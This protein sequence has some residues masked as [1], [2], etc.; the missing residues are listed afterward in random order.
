MDHNP[1]RRHLAKV[2]LGGFNTIARGL[3][4]RSRSVAPSSTGRP[5]GRLI[6]D[7]MTSEGIQ[8]AVE[9]YQTQPTTLFTSFEY[10][11]EKGGLFQHEF[12][13]THINR[14]T[15]CRFDRRAMEGR[16]LG[17][18]QRAGT[19]AEDS[20]HILH[21]YQAEYQS[22]LSGSDVLL[23]IE[24]PKTE[25]L[26]FILAV[27]HAIQKH[28]LA[29]SYSLFGY[30]C[31]FF[32]WTMTAIIARRSYAWEAIMAPD[33][34]WRD[35]V[36]AAIDSAI[37]P[38]AQSE[39]ITQ[40]AV[41][42]SSS[43]IKAWFQKRTEPNQRPSIPKYRPEAEFLG[44]FQSA[45]KRHLNLK[46]YQKYIIERLESIL[47]K[48]Q[49]TSLIAEEV[50]HRVKEAVQ[51]TKTSLAKR[52]SLIAAE[53]SVTSS[54]YGSKDFRKNSI[55]TVARW[56]RDEVILL[57]R[58]GVAKS[59]AAAIKALATNYHDGVDN[60]ILK[61]Q[62]YTTSLDEAWDN[63]WEF[64]WVGSISP[65]QMMEQG[66]IKDLGNKA[67]ELGKESWKIAWQAYNELEILILQSLTKTLH[68]RLVDLDL[69][70]L[71]YGNSNKK[72]RMFRRMQWSTLQ[73]DVAEAD[74]PH[75][76]DF[77]RR[78]I[79][80]HFD[81]VNKATFRSY[82]NL[83]GEV[84]GT[85]TGVWKEALQSFHELGKYNEGPGAWHALVDGGLE[86]QDASGIRG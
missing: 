38:S 52:K 84:E 74:K 18:V 65:R 55:I 12:I 64:H 42:F 54:Y 63:A 24:F 7:L 44:E 36:E 25:D 73:R 43:R 68:E 61:S 16:Q 56:S 28:L 35:M 2:T 11:K 9:W 4:Q 23:R 10:R 83:R 58:E 8:K 49:L 76:Q 47:L 48:S 67:S 27:C 14:N 86:H 45:L 30:N 82:E 5:Q 69:R 79:H 6:L 70:H 31:Y 21:S 80:I 32:S 29:K 66:E 46:G 17:A 3:A 39:I 78:R 59:T 40:R 62:Y 15:L 72:K 37:S 41:H 57:V 53:E 85:M 51:Q 77:I 34:A 19:P 20:A 75:L 60:D 22:T 13:V 1:F 33:F 50:I 26:Q 71:E 81:S